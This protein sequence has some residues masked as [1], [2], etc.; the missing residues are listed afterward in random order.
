MSLQFIKTVFSAKS[1]IICS[2]SCVPL[3]SKSVQ[4][5]RAICGM[6]FASTDL[7]SL[8]AYKEDGHLGEGLNLAGPCVEQEHVSLSAA[9]VNSVLET[10]HM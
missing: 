6:N 8:T 2:V 4:N 5:Y 7:A 3:V 9:P 1:P 10:Q